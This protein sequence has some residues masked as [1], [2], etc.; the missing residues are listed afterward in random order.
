MAT[1]TDR[2]DAGSKL[3]PQLQG[4]PAGSL[5]DP[6]QKPRSQAPQQGPAQKRPDLLAALLDVTPPYGAS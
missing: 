5:I 2:S 1:A 6:T 4:H 3:G